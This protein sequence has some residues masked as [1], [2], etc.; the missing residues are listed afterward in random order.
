MA[1]ENILPLLPL[2]DIVIFPYM[3]VPLF[4]GR[5]RSK[6]AL[7]FALEEKSLVF[8]VT[9]KNPQV[10]TPSE[11]D[12]H[13]VGTIGS[14]I[15]LLRLPDGTTKVLMEGLK[16]AK[17]DE[18]VGNEPYFQVKVSQITE[19]APSA[20]EV[21]ALMRSIK[22]SF[23][24]YVKLNKNIPPE[25]LLTVSNIDD[26]VQF[27]FMVV[28]QL[29]V[30][31]ADRQGL[32]EIVDTKERLEKILSLI[33]SEIEILEVERRIRGRVKRQMEKSQ[34]EYYLNE[35]MT[36]IQKELGER[37][38]FKT[39]L[40]TIEQKLNEKSLSPEARNKARA[41]LR[42]LKMMSPMSAEATVIRNYL[43]WLLTIPWPGDEDDS[44]FDMAYAESVLDEDHYGLNKVKERILEHLAVL[45]VSKEVRSPILCFVGPPGVGKTSLGKSVARALRRSFVRNSLGGVRD[46]AEIRGHRRT[47][48]G[49]LPGRVI[50]SMKKAGKINPVF[51][52]DEIDKMSQDFRGDPASAMLEVLDPEQNNAFGD[53][54]LEVDYDLTKV[55]FIATANQLGTIPRPLLDRMEI[56]EISSYTSVE[57]F[58]IAKKHLV[59]K[60]IKQ[61]GMKNS[62]LAIADE[63]VKEL[64][65][66]YTKEAGVRNL[67]RMI[68]STVRKSIT[69]TIRANQKRKSKKAAG[70]KTIKAADI[71]RY[72]GPSKYR[73]NRVEK[74]NKVG[75]VAG[76]AW[77]EMGG[78]LLTI[79]ATAMPGSGKLSIT[80]QLGDV[81][82]ESAQ[83]AMSY[84]RSRADELEL[85]ENFYKEVDIHI[86]VPEGAIPKD[87]P[88]A[89]ITMATAIT[90]SLL[91][92]PV[93]ALIAM[94]GEITLRGQI[95]PIGGLREKILAASRAGI[96]KVLIPKENERDL[97][98]IPKEIK[99]KVQI[100]MVDHLDA[101]LKESL[102][103]PKGIKLFK[104]GSTKTKAELYRASGSSA[105]Q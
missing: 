70:K 95:L 13:R 101:V 16:R 57:K 8:L 62:Q 60:Q 31:L 45:S 36:A 10:N 74:E 56:I 50:Q 25:I 76:L 102:I 73:Y 97:E 77:T 68:A 71:R 66:Y 92:Y 52:L 59:P 48:I 46:E 29:N 17:I 85:P 19:T 79:E 58:H 43:D 27:G 54:Y 4:V 65:N 6:A 11:R 100:V 67:E 34:R 14:V 18:F 3:V 38:E 32:L 55:F 87:G 86:H 15:Q 47:Y 84:V 96:K 75:I 99:S 90:S 44:H 41:E 7:E 81:M 104:A 49:A 94:T 69:E 2:R 51:M 61:H 103:I 35:Q 23:E 40:H 78:D 37:D 91:K 22:E 83:A 63:A 80:G 53:H 28:A 82:K 5:D 105:L 1:K 64:I 30:K 42:K 98:E 20:V 72:F 39:E 93:N 26:P 33:Q 21:K 88:S 9:Q 12:L 24:Q 89:G